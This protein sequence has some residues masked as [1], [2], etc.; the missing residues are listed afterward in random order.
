[1]LYGLQTQGSSWSKILSEQKYILATRITVSRKCV[2]NY[3]FKEAVTK[4]RDGN[5][6]CIISFG[7]V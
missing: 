6:Q 2:E 1:M 7:A 3:F 4:M 5:A